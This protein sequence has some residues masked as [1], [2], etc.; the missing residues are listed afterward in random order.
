M[1]FLRNLKEKL[2]AW[3]LFE[4]ALL[5]ALKGISQTEVAKELPRKV[6]LALESEKMI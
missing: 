3:D 1:K 4:T 5:V 2:L 6:G